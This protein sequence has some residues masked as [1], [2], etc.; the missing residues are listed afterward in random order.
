LSNAPTPRRLVVRISPD[1]S[2]GVRMSQ[3]SKEGSM[4]RRIAL[5]IVAV[6]CSL[7]AMGAVAQDEEATTVM[8]AESEELGQFLTDADGMTLYLFTNDTEEGVSSC[9][10]DCEARWPIFRAEEPLTL[11]EG[12]E[13]E[14][15]LIERDDGTTQVAYNGIPLYYWQNDEQPGDTT[16]HGVGDVW[17]VVAPGEQFGDRA[18]MMAMATPSP[19]GSPSPMAMADTTVA[20]GSSDALGEFLTDASGMTLYMFTNDTEPNVSACEG[21][22]LVAWPAFTAEEP[23]TLPEGVEGELTL[24]ERSDG[25]MQVAYNGMPLYYWQNDAQA[26]DTTGHE[27]GGVWFVVPPGTQ[28]GEIQPIEE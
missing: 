26:G 17:F 5:F 11:P 22:C 10:G 2:G 15:T 1:A 9:Y 24:F 19:A 14:L 16:G 27:V 25:T 7:P 3:C 18:G 20:V 13:G 4:K 28:F 6:L 8:V 12:V 23:L 21:D